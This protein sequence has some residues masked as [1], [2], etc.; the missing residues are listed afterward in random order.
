ML[1]KD[2]QSM[3]IILLSKQKTRGPCLDIGC[4]D[5]EL[6]ISIAKQKN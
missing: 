1:K 3:L 2:L 5:G 6:A 4:G